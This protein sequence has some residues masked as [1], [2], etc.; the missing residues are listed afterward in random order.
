MTRREALRIRLLALREARDL[1]ERDIKVAVIEARI[2][3]LTDDW[4]G[5]TLGYRGGSSV[6]NRYGSRKA[7][8]AATSLTQQGL[9]P[10]SPG[11]APARPEAPKVRSSPRH[12]HGPG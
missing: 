8:E 5:G 1:I 6:A 10:S 4:I 9:P 2:M 7:I 3:G 11:S 12:G